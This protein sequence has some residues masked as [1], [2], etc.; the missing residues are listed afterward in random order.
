VTFFLAEVHFNDRLTRLLVVARHFAAE[1]LDYFDGLGLV[2]ARRAGQD[3]DSRQGTKG[4]S[5]E[6]FS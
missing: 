2:G 3:H 4:P 1:F 5:H 6:H